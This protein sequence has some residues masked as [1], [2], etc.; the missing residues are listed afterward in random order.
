L[1]FLEE[2]VLQF[3]GQLFQTFQLQLGEVRDVDELMF[4]PGFIDILVAL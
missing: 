3:V 2:R 4:L 1:T